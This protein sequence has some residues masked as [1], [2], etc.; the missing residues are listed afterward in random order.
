[1]DRITVNDYLFIKE[2]M[3][4]VAKFDPRPAIANWLS[5]RQQRT[6]NCKITTAKSISTNGASSFFFI[7]AGSLPW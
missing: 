7:Q 6:K 3:G 1:M 2:S 4:P 5:V